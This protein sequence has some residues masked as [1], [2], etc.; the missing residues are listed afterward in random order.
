M[1]PNSEFD[2]YIIELNFK[3]PITDNCE[4]YIK[5]INTQLEEFNIKVIQQNDI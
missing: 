1:Y 4:K 3:Y 5:V 2:Y